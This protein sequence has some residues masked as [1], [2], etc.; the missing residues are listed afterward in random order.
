[1]KAIKRAI[2]LCWIMLV[3]CCIIKLFGGNWFEIICN[4]EHFIRICNYIDNHLALKYC[5]AFPIYLG[6]TYI[7]LV[8]CSLLEKPN[9]KQLIVII[10]FIVFVWATQFISMLTKMIIEIIM[11]IA[12]PFIIRLISVGKNNWKIALKKT[13]YLGIIGYLLAL[14]FQVLS[15]VTRNIGIKIVDENIL[16]S[17]ILMI[18]YYIM[19]VI[20]YLYVILKL[21]SQKE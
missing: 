1:M 17:F 14:I 11:F 3:I 13:W 10:G 21:K 5:I 4:N 16:I 19:L 15:L 18:D 6:S 9:Y 7:I 8:A 20:Y 12:L 2:I